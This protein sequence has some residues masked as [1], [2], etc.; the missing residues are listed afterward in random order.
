MNKKK[1]S[2]NPDTSIRKTEDIKNVVQAPVFKPKI[3]IVQVLG[4]TIST[5]FKC[6]FCKAQI[7]VNQ[8][9]ST[10]KCATCH[11][12]QLIE[13]V[14]QSIKCEIK[15]KK[16][17][18]NTITFL[19]PSEIV[20]E[21]TGDIPNDDKEIYLLRCKLRVSFGRNTGIAIAATKVA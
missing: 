20:Q 8:E 13:L 4:V 17:D 18:D 15:A 3:E 11:K 12:R 9:I 16:T 14:D 10:V 2:T 1:L 21:L 19:I 5:T 7:D 6:C